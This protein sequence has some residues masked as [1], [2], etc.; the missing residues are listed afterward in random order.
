VTALYYRRKD[1]KRTRIEVRCSVITLK[2]EGGENEEN[3][4]SRE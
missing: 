4:E 2:K 3:I 1:K